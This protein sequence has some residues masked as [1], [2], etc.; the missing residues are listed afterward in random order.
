VGDQGDQ[1]GPEQVEMLFD[2]ERPQD[3]ERVADGGE[4]AVVAND[5][6]IEIGTVEQG[7]E[8]GRESYMAADGDEGS[9]RQQDIGGGGR[10]QPQGAAEIKAGEVY[11]AVGCQELTGDQEAAEEKK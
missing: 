9:A 1:S 4:G 6:I 11:F 2:G 3:V 7:G 8:E 10:H 5:E